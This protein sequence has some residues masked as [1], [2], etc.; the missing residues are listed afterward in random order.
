MKSEQAKVREELAISLEELQ[1]DLKLRY[2][3]VL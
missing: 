3:K 2:S 1:R